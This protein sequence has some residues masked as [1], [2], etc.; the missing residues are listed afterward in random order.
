M[1]A[2]KSTEQLT[3][4]LIQNYESQV[5]HLTSINETNKQII[6]LYKDTLEKSDE[7]VE[8]LKEKVYRLQQQVIRLS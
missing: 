5:N 7:Y 2:E 8:L 6:E 3:Q 1:S 4:E